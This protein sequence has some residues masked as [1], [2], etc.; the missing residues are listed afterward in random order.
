MAQEDAKSILKEFKDRYSNRE[1]HQADLSYKVFKGHDAKIPHENS[2]GIYYKKGNSVYSKIAEAEI[3]NTPSLYLKINHKEKAILI[4]NGTNLSASANQFNLDQLFQ[5]LDIDTLVVNP[6]SWKIVLKAKP[7]TQLPYSTVEIEI[8]KSTYNLKRQVFYY[9][10]KI[11]FSKELKKS[12]IASVKL[13]VTYKNYKT[14]K[15]TLTNKVFDIKQYISKKNAKYIAVNKYK[16]YDIV[17]IVRE[18]K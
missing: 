15:F 11:D 17:D 18:N 3:I 2:K 1:N 13:E 10:N 9:I 4:A 8:D 5:F 6:T 14:K 16:G 12:D 7:I